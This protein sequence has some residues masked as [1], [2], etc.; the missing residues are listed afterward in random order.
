MDIDSWLIVVFLLTLYIY[1]NELIRWNT[2]ISC[3][4]PH[5]RP[6][7]ILQRK[8]WIGPEWDLNPRPAVYMTAALTNWA[9]RPLTPEKPVS[10]YQSISQSVNQSIYIYLH[11]ITVKSLTSWCMI[12]IFWGARGVKAFKT[13][14]PY[15]Q[16]FPLPTPCFEMFFLER[17]LNDTHPH[18]PSWSIHHRYSPLHP[19]PLPL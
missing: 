17:F 14:S 9:T 2:D 5:V 18:H 3:L 6:N 10:W 12:R 15:K 8:N 16:L 1:L 19:P 13:P 7:A 4:Q 11:K